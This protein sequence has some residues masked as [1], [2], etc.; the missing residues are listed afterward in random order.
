MRSAILSA[1][2][3]AVTLHA[4]LSVVWANEHSF[5]AIP[6]VIAAKANKTI[7]VT[8]QQASAKIRQNFISDETQNTVH[9]A[10][11]KIAIEDF[12][13]LIGRPVSVNHKSW[14]YGGAATGTRVHLFGKPKERNGVI[15][16]YEAAELINVFNSIV[17]PCDDSRADVDGFVVAQANERLLT[18]PV[19]DFTGKSVSCTEAGI[20][21]QSFVKYGMSIEEVEALVGK[22]L[23]SNSTDF[24]WRFSDTTL[25]TPSL[26]FVGEKVD[27]AFRNQYL[28][29]W[30]SDI[31]GC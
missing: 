19:E 1:V 16:S 11:R 25:G 23:H 8:C 12:G 21:I 4:P 5:S 24:R 31:R 14:L 9:L 29:A 17:K 26:Y 6:S 30:K 27:G 13:N 3:A 18:G 20:R 15:A 28:A 7:S 22:K 2:L 10:D